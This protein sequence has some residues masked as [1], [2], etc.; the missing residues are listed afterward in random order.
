MKATILAVCLI[1]LA[2]LLPA[3][4][5][6]PPGPVQGYWDVAGS[7]YRITGNIDVPINT[8]LTIGPGVEVVFQGTYKLDVLGQIISNGNAENL[9][10]F[11]A[12]DTLNGWQSIRFTNNGNTQPPSSFHYTDF[13]YGKAVH[14]TAPLD[15]MNCGGAVWA[16][17]AGTLTF[18]HCNFKRCKSMG[19]GS[20]IFAEE[21]TNIVM[22]HCSIA[23]CDTE[24]F[25]AICAKNG[26]VNIQN[27][28]FLNN[29]SD[30]FGAAMYLYECPEVNIISCKFINSSAGAVAGIYCLYSPLVIKNSLF[31]GNF[32]ETGRGGA[33]GVTHGTATITNCTFANNTSPMEGGAIWFNVLD[34]PAVI[35]NTVFWDNLPNAI[36]TITS[37]YTL[38][39]CS[40]QVPQGGNTNIWGNPLFTNPNNQDFTLLPSSPCIDAGTPDVTGLN[41]PPVDLAG[42][43]R[44]VDGNMDSIV[45]ID[46]GCYE[47]PAPEAMGE[48]AGQVI[49]SQSQAVAGAVIT[50]G[51]LS[52]VTNTWGLYALA[53]EQGTYSVTC[54]K[55]GYDPV[56]HE[57]IEV[58][59]GQ[60]TTVNFILN[61]VSNS[62]PALIPVVTHLTSSPNPFADHTTI[63]ISLSRACSLRIE[64][65]NLKGQK[66]KTLAKGNFSAGNH[67]LPWN[68]FDDQ[69]QEAGN[70]IFLYRLVCERES[71]TQRL[72]KF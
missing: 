45:R 40:M 71:R 70:G 25:G 67:S 41:L 62:D 11:T 49:D 53:L 6:I 50:A 54:T 19:D 27:T 8:T 66:I 64:I 58:S 21:S 17:N 1:T 59:T 38:S 63:S 20:V 34:I 3:E 46:I 16:V 9:V 56:T 7:P 42:L 43:P 61:S 69:N 4:T 24:W 5:I 28:E 32:T 35:T 65:F 68:G 72:I 47:M 18:E 39:Y 12:Q 13:R 22:N 31:T 37:T 55:Q 48:I 26:T 15:P 23:N 44:I 60:T 14:G 52:T 10:Y 2:S 33:I 30:V 57:N 51:G 29:S 36:S